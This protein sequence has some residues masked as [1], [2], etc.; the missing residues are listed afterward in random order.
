VRVLWLAAD[1]SRPKIGNRRSKIGPYRILKK[2]EN[3]IARH[4]DDVAHRKNPNRPKIRTV[5][6]G[7]IGPEND[8]LAG[9]LQ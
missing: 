8:D 5:S 3:I 4:F 2:G 6:S 9:R 1:F 7:L